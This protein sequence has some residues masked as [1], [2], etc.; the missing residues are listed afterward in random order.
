MKIPIQMNNTVETKCFKNKPFSSEIIWERALDNLIDNQ[1]NPQLCDW[2]NMNKGY[3]LKKLNE[4][5]IY[6]FIARPRN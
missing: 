6:L 5:M 2:F 3:Y 4:R 1:R